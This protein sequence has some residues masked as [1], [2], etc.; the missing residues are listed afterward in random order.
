[1]LSLN[2]SAIV[3]HPAR[4]PPSD[5]SNILTACLEISELL[6]HFIPEKDPIRG[7][8]EDK[9]RAVNLI[10]PFFNTKPH[11]NIEQKTISINDVIINSQSLLHRLIG[12]AIK[13]VI[14]PSPDSGIVQGNPEQIEQILLNLAVSAR[15]AMPSGGIFI[16]EATTVELFETSAEITNL[17]IPPGRYI[18]LFIRYIGRNDEEEIPSNMDGLNYSGMRFQ[19]SNLGFASVYR[20]VKQNRGDIL[21]RTEKGKGGTVIIYL[22]RADVPAAL[23]DKN[24]FMAFHLS[25][26][27]SYHSSHVI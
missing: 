18:K 5:F 7:D 20:V 17:S 11:P 13:L 14:I 8:I 16:I 22:P 19:E 9:K 1:M 25:T 6:L 3:E 15:D 4:K 12:S 2:Q 24:P 27:P 23:P 10:K 21:I 26:Y